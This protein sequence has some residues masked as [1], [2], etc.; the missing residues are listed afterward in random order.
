[1][2]ASDAIEQQNDHVRCK[3]TPYI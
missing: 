1:L 3:R 2:I